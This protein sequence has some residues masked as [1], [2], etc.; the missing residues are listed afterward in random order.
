MC[1]YSSSIEPL[2]LPQTRARGTGGRGAPA[3][4]HYTGT[5]QGIFPPS[6]FI[7]VCSVSFTVC[8]SSY[9]SECCFHSR[10]RRLCGWQGLDPRTTS[11]ATI[12]RA[13]YRYSALTKSE[14]KNAVRGGRGGIRRNDIYAMP[15]PHDV[16]SGP[17]HRSELVHVITQGSFRQ[18]T[19]YFLLVM[20]SFSSFSSSARSA[21]FCSTQR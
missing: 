19:V 18:L 17:S 1:S 3:L 13:F 9:Y 14:T 5:P 11:C 4:P 12:N 20:N 2:V 21:S 16:F 7:L 15:Y 8:F 10:I 6:L